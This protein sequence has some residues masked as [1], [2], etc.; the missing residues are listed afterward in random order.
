MKMAQCRTI[1][2]LTSEILNR[3]SL[4]LNQN[5][6]RTSI[7]DFRRFEMK[8]AKDYTRRRAPGMQED[9]CPS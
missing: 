9:S 8:S 3:C 6:Y 2:E 4:F 1:R 5:E 7:N